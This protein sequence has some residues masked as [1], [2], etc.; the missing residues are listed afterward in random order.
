MIDI[1]DGYLIYG[2]FLE[3]CKWDY[4]KQLIEESSPKVLY[5]A[6]PIIWLKPI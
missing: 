5:T 6:V 2:L 3:G 1:R 4:L